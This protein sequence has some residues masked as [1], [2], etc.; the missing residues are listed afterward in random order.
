MTIK[1][2][3]RDGEAAN[4]ALRGLVMGSKAANA[5]LQGDRVKGPLGPVIRATLYTEEIGRDWDNVDNINL[6]MT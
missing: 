2:W 4:A 1:R 3:G 6:S 5:A